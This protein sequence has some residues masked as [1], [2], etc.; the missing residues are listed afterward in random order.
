[1]LLPVGIE[2]P[3]FRALEL[4]ARRFGF[5][6][7]FDDGGAH[8]GLERAA[9][10]IGFD[11]VLGRAGDERILQRDASDMRAQTICRHRAA[12][13]FAVRGVRAR[14]GGSDMSLPFPVWPS[15]RDMS[16]AQDFRFLIKAAGGLAGRNWMEPTSAMQ[17]TQESESLKIGAAIA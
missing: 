1:N 6:D 7:G 5:I 16:C 2:H 11:H 3:V 9:H 15:L 8:A 12:L 10:A 14:L 17:A 13:L 4:I